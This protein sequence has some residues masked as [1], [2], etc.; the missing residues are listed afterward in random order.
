MLPM[1]ISSKFRGPETICA[2]N[3]IAMPLFF[4]PLTSKMAQELKG[5]RHEILRGKLFR[6]PIE[7]AFCAFRAEG[8]A[9]QANLSCGAPP[10]KKAKLDARAA[11][12][13]G[14]PAK[15]LEI[16]EVSLEEDRMTEMVGKGAL[17]KDKMFDIPCL[18][19]WPFSAMEFCFGRAV[20]NFLGEISLPTQLF[21]GQVDVDTAVQKT[22]DRLDVTPVP[23]QDRPFLN[24][25]SWK[26]L[27]ARTPQY[28]Q[29][30]FCAKAFAGKSVASNFSFAVYEKFKGLAAEMACAGR[31]HGQVQRASSEGIQPFASNEW[32]RVEHGAAGYLIMRFF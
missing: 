5:N 13:R 19:P 6:S 9:L 8:R 17:N 12:I 28:F 31:A 1:K 24:T 22:L 14:L 18:A 25:R 3:C 16:L 2:S 20:C 21:V 27:L 26:A 29:K 30:Y 15:T 11:L 23:A 10:S 4:A 32:S 7:A